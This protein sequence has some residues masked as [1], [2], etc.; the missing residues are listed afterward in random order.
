MWELHSCGPGCILGG[1]SCADPA[2]LPGCVNG[3][4]DAGVMS[5][6]L[7]G[8]V[9]APALKPGLANGDACPTVL[10]SWSPCP[11]AWCCVVILFPVSASVL[12][13]FFGLVMGGSDTLSAG[14]LLHVILPLEDISPLL[15]INSKHSQN[16][17]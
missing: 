15:P 16:L 14:P 12:V 3:L 11:S 13:P 2:R 6:V 7:A 10:P 1:S 8:A 9:L 5:A 4:V 17:T